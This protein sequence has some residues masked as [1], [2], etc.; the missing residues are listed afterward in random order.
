M[1]LLINTYIFYV[2]FILAVGAAAYLVDKILTK[3]DEKKSNEKPSK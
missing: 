2:S 1:E 3:Y